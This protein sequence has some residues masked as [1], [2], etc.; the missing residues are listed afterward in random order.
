[1]SGRWCQAV[2]DAFPHP[3]RWLTLIK[4]SSRGFLRKNA[5]NS[6]FWNSQESSMSAFAN[7][8]VCDIKRHYA[9]RPDI[10]FFYLSPV[11]LEQRL[12]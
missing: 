1:M 5:R 8:I 6:F 10:H 2:H 3:R 7:E 4:S 9:H 11:L 12:S